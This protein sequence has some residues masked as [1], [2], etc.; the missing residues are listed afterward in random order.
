[1]G[2][3]SPTWAHLAEG[4]YRRRQSPKRPELRERLKNTHVEAE[5][6]LGRCRHA[7]P[8]WPVATALTVKG[9]DPKPKGQ[10]SGR[11]PPGR[12]GFL[13]FWPFG[14]C[15][16]FVLAFWALISLHFGLLGLDCL[17]LALW[18]LI[19]FHFAFGGW[20]MGPAQPIHRHLAGTQQLRRSCT[21]TGKPQ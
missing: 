6:K 19:S 13:S 1:M 20:S 9:T 4:S 3:S 10:C 17:C 14:P 15:F 21:N 11:T 12:A 5:V 7:L 8:T 18:A 16:P 2:T